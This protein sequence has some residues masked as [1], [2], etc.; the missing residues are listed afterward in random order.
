MKKT[1]TLTLLEELCCKL[2]IIVKYDK[3]FGKGGY[4][5]LRDKSYFIINERLSSDAKEQIF[6][7]EMSTFDVQN[8]SL[9]SKLKELFE[10]KCS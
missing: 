6:I 2:S 4:C 10:K 5:R 3:F 1:S 9:P 8:L 7:K